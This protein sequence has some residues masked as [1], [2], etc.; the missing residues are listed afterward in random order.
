MPHPR[1]LPWAASAGIP[2]VTPSAQHSDGLQQRLHCHSQMD[3]WLLH[4]FTI[5]A[6]SCGA[7]RWAA[8]AL[9]SGSQLGG[10]G[11]DE[12]V[13]GH[14]YSHGQYEARMVTATCD[15]IRLSSLDHEGAKS[16]LV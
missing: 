12:A 8:Q 4:I 15:P 16:C 7:P 11:T 2:C 10:R 9:G 14:F 13:P 1:T 6:W 3:R 5:E